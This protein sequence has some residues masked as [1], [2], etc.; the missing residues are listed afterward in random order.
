MY[1]Y[2]VQQEDVDILKQSVRTVFCRIELMNSDWQV[3][4]SLEG[5]LFNDSFSCDGESTTRR[6]YN[7]DVVVTDST[8]NVGDDTKIWIDRYIRVYYGVEHTRSKEIRWYRIGTFTFCDMNYKTSSSESTLSLSCLDCMANYDGTKGGVMVYDTEADVTFKVL[9]GQKIQEVITALVEDAG[10]TNYS[11]TGTDDQV[12]PYDIEWQRGTTY[13]QAW[14][15]IRDL[16]DYW[17]FFFDEDG[18]FIWRKT[19][20]GKGEAIVLDDSVLRPLIV[21]ETLND[22][23]KGVYNATEIWGR[24]LDIVDDDRYAKTCTG[25]T[26]VSDNVYTITL[27]GITAW[28]QIDNLTNFAIKVSGT[29]GKYINVNDLSNSL[30]K[31]S[32][33]KNVPIYI[34]TSHPELAD[35]EYQTN[36]VYVFRYYR[37]ST[38][39]SGLQD[40]ANFQ[41]QG[42]YQAHGLYEETNPNVPYSIPNVGYK[43]P[44]VLEMTQLCTDAL[45]QSQAEYETYKTTAKQDSI[46][47]NMMI[48]PFLEPGQKLEYTPLHADHPDE[49]II[50]NLSWSTFTGTMSVSIYRFLEDYSYVVNN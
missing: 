31:G 7:C 29:Y 20:T 3:V 30:V 36:Q 25:G 44:R 49:W 19:L 9:A 23:F 37:T 35:N 45:C 38:G 16:F 48:I 26:S 46:T 47:L 22:S 15:T 6:T 42:Q 43:I 21:D 40:D 50:K 34:D 17:E 1:N 2:I 32:N 13:C 12:I 28:N 18:T 10:I 41:L 4:D 24:E 39:A 33:K 27:D 14:T 8:F 11:V 5:H